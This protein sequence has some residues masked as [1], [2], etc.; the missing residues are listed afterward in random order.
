MALEGLSFV[1]NWSARNV[2]AILRESG[3]GR[4]GRNP[5]QSSQGQKNPL[6]G[7]GHCKR[8][9]EKLHMF[10]LKSCQEVSV[11]GTQWAGEG[12]ELGPGACSRDTREGRCRVNEGRQRLMRLLIGPLWVPPWEQLLEG[13]GWSQ[14]NTETNI[15]ITQA[16][17]SGGPGQRHSR[18]GEQHQ[19]TSF[20]IS[21]VVTKRLP[22]APHVEWEK[23]INQG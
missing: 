2:L 9:E 6:G 8:Q 20:H 23:R 15:R 16:N 19:V 22:E 1:K 18:A 7:N 5:P 13:Q 21:R 10:H 14:E 11:A 17:C 12:A 3:M 4:W